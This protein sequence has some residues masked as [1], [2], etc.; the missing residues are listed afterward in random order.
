MAVSDRQFGNAHE[1]RARERKAADIISHVRIQ[2]IK[3]ADI[4]AMSP[5]ERTTLLAGAGHGHASEE[6]WGLVHKTLGTLE[7]S[8]DRDPFAG[9]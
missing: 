1:Q 3:S 6:T 4:K 2:G 5:E 9:L 8:D 7:K